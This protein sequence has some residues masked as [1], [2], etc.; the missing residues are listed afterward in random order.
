MEGRADL[1]DASTAERA[2]LQRRHPGWGCHATAARTAA[3]NARR[4]RTAR[5]NTAHLRA[6]SR[7]EA[8]L[9]RRRVQ[10]SFQQQS[11]GVRRQTHGG[12]RVGAA[13]AAAVSGTMRARVRRVA[14]AMVTLVVFFVAL[15]V[16]R[17]E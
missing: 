4:V 3:L 11:A 7:T 1:P 15:A 14:P 6:R 8:A 10:P 9:A 12:D 16:L 2:W 13:E 17:A 5:G